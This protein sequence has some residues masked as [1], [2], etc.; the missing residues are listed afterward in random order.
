MVRS[1]ECHAI[2]AVKTEKIQNGSFFWSLTIPSWKVLLY[3]VNK[4]VHV[5]VLEWNYWYYMIL[6]K[7]SFYFFLNILSQILFCM[8]DQLMRHYLAPLLGLLSSYAYIPMVSFLRYSSGTVWPPTTIKFSAWVANSA[9][10]G[11]GFDKKSKSDINLVDNPPTPI[12][13]SRQSLPGLSK[14]L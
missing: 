8:F 12:V 10:D 5:T 3:Y 9:H 13:T 14:D 1:K 2:L 4:F 6:N 11:H 7:I